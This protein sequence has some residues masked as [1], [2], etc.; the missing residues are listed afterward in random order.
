M[1]I[2]RVG[3]VG[4]GIMGSRMAAMLKQR[5]F[6]VTV[7]NRTSSKAE[8]LKAKGLHVARSPRELMERVEAVVTCVADPKALR[9]VTFGPEGLLA[10][11][12][13][14]QVVIDCSTISV[15]LVHELN[16]EWQA[17]QC[18]FV[19]APVT[20]SKGGAEKGTLV[21]MVGAT[22]EGLSQATP[23]LLGMGEKIIHC[24]PVGAGTQV[25]LAGNLLIA[26]MLQAFS[27]GMLL[28]SKA[29]ADPRK[30]LEVIQASGFRSPY[31]EFKAPALLNHAYE[32]HFSIDLMH[33]DLSLFVESASEHQVPTPTAASLKETYNLA[34]AAGKGELDIAAVISVFEQLTGH[35][36]R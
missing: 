9:E 21:I 24:G 19:D 11:A 6:D 33:K 17:K 5:G 1:A 27:E 8:A 7:F 4:L 23:V 29:G 35:Q 14:G 28:T 18:T 10:G 16:G 30:L 2:T 12:K 15:G 34:R 20:G 36:M 25:K 32:T 13:A 22:A 26:G 3:F 31:F